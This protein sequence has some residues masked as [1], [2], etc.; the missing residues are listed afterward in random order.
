MACTIPFEFQAENFEEV[1]VIDGKLTDQTQRHSVRLS[2]TRP[3]GQD[4]VQSIVSDA[5]VKIQN[6]EGG[7]II[8]EYMDGAY[9]TP[10]NFSG[11]HGV[12]YRLEVI[13]NDGTTYQSTFE[14]LIPSPPIDS[15]YDVFA[16]IS[17]SD[18]S[19][20]DQGIQF[21]LDTHDDSEKARF[22]RYEYDE[23][24]QVRVPYPSLFDIRIDTFYIEDE[25]GE[26][27]LLLDTAIFLRD[28]TVGI[29][30]EYDESLGLNIGS[31][32]N[33]QTNHLSEHPLT[34]IS[35]TSQKI[36]TRYSILAK[37]YTISQEAFLYYR[38][39][40]ENNESTGTLFDK[41]AGTIN[42]NVH[43]I[44]DPKEAVLGY[45]EVSGYTESRELFRARDFDRRFRAADFRYD[46]DPGNILTMQVDSAKEFMFP[47]NHNRY[48]IY[49]YLITEG[50]PGDSLDSV[51]I[52][53][54]LC[55]SCAEY[56]DTTTPDFWIED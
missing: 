28:D 26:L 8:L 19:R 29:C 38:K 56:A 6:D 52:A 33:N 42:G 48:H 7:E 2:Y 54:R 23:T 13:M 5:Q 1:L 34:F 10:S 18:Q 46:C 36:R 14:E 27:E 35:Q 53:I 40:I 15:I 21:F 24:W 32:A 55:T 30:Y 22:F 9:H 43:N 20:N 25:E 47:F 41:Q 50:A 16:E 49:S 4:S 31:T 51:Y 37:Q 45:F 17:F 44:D 39:L 12:S 3:L 11:V